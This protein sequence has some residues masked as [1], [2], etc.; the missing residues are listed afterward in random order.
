[1]AGSWSAKR[2]SSDAERVKRHSNSLYASGVACPSIQRYFLIMGREY[3]IAAGLVLALGFALAITA[4]IRQILEGFLGPDFVVFWQAGR[5]A[6]ERPGDLYDFGAITGAQQWITH[7]T[8]PRPF[9][10]PPSALLLFA[11]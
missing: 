7:P 11:P 4:F 8:G 9:A 5:F 1:M 6:L 3:R 2:P 10:N